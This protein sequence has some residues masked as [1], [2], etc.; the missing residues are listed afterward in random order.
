[1]NFT[2]NLSNMCHAKS[3]DINPFKIIFKIK[4]PR[5]PAVSNIWP[6]SSVLI[7]EEGTA[8]SV[9]TFVFAFITV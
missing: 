3:P 6:F 5:F 2:R 4:N 9:Y 1:M 8:P 7:F